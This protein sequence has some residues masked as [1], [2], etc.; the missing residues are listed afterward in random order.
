MA[1]RKSSKKKKNTAWWQWIIVAVAAFGLYKAMDHYLAEPQGAASK[2]TPGK[3]TVASKDK[4]PEKKPAPAKPEASPHPHASPTPEPRPS[5]HPT[6]TAGPVA[7]WDFKDTSRLLPPDA[8]PDNYQPI[9]VQGNQVGLLA[10][11]KLIPG[12]K[13]G[14]KGLTNTRPGLAWY[15]L[16]NDKYQEQNL[17]FDELKPVLGAATVQKMSGLPEVNPVPLVKGDKTLFLSRLFLGGDPMEAEAVLEA[18]GSGLRWA[19]LADAS[20]KTQPA[21]FLKGTTKLTTREFITVKRQ[22]KIYL[23]ASSGSLNEAKLYEGY[24]WK[25]SAYFWDGNRFVYDPEFS[26]KLTKEKK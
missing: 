9:A 19:N 7:K 14:P 16:Q 8:F 20:G 11:A 26:E 5:P 25:V 12:K 13:P 17:N 3:I 4:T 10:H 6:P 2:K 18:D 15:K 22:N 23:V 1:K 24:R 21:A